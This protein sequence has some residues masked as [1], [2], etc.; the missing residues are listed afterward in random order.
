VQLQD[1][2][3][4]ENFIFELQCNVMD[5]KSKEEYNCYRKSLAIHNLKKIEKKKLKKKFVNTSSEGK[6]EK[7]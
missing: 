3:N 2:V 1:Y 6:Q 4:P 5:F 7:N